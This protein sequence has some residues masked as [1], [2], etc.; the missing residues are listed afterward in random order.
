MICKE[1]VLKRGNLMVS[2]DKRNKMKKK[3]NKLG[4]IFSF[5]N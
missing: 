5:E 2:N 3:K 1:E 4:M